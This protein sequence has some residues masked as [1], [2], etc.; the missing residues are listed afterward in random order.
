MLCTLALALLGYL[1]VLGRL[2]MVQE[3][4][5]FR[6]TTLSAEHQF[7]LPDDVHEVNI[8]VPGARLNALHMR[9]PHPD[10][11]VFYLHG[12]A[13]N[14]ATWFVNADYWR[15]LNVDLFMVDY[16]GYG[17]STGHIENEAQLMADVQAAWQSIAPSYSGRHVV[18][19]GRSLGTGLATKL[20]ASLAPKQRPDLLALVSPY[21]SMLALSQEKY[22]LLPAGLVLRYPLHTDEALPVLAG[23]PTR[24]LLLHGDQDELIPIQHAE[25][26]SRLA[27]SAVQLQR[28]PGAGHSD[29]QRTPVY[30]NALGQAVASAVRP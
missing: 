1:G 9:L 29:I 5:L 24:V 28:V 8:D 19:F 7:K 27:P 4:L 21:R 16:R 15:A 12:N 18:F 13:G 2:W 22:P 30:L 23:Q 17:K 11:V 20:A 6:P 25:A 14:L 3:S 10:G 26:L